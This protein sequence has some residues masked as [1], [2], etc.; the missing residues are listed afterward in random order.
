MKQVSKA[1]FLAMTVIDIS[2][3]QYRESEGVAVMV[4]VAMMF[5]G[6]TK[7]RHTGVSLNFVRTQSLKTVVPQLNRDLN[8]HPPVNQL[9]AFTALL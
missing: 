6:R 7:R 4:H 2:T 1:T 8:G 9:A 5:T 3:D